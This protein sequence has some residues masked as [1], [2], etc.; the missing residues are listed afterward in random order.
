MASADSQ[1]DLKIAAFTVADLGDGTRLQGFEDPHGYLADFRGAG[2]RMLAENPH[3]EPSD[4][5]LILAVDGKRV[6]GRL[7]FFAGP[8]PSGA[9]DSRVLWLSGYF[10]QERY[11]ATGAGGMLMLRALSTRMTL[12]AAGG[13][14]AALQRLYDSTGFRRLPELK[15][16]FRI[17]NPRLITG[18]Y[19]QQ[20][21]MRVLLRPV[22]AVLLRLHGLFFRPRLPGGF[23]FIEVAEFDAGIDAVKP[24]PATAWFPRS[25]AL[26]NWILRF[27]WSTRGFLIRRNGV[28]AGY[29]ILGARRMARGPAPGEAGAMTWGLLVDYRLLPGDAAAMNALVS[30]SIRH[31]EALGVDALYCQGS[32]E[33]LHAACRSYGMV[34]YGGSLVFLRPGPRWRF[35]VDRPWLL[36]AATADVTLYAD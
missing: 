1:N 32:D 20:A 2:A 5:A 16:Y 8:A 7:G 17:F 33:A 13:P 23:E 31:C 22:V 26:L 27:R 25:H 4:L 19:L 28:L 3:A 21:W 10:L 15:G 18:R 30:F 6:V 35:D 29:C 34:A 24:D 36:T 11:L 12:L 14:N 9:I